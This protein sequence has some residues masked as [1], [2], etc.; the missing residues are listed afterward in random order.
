MLSAPVF[1][2]SL[3]VNIYGSRE[4]F[5]NEYRNLLAD[6]LLQSLNYDISREVCVA[7][8]API[9]SPYTATS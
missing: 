3:L 7:E 4:M 2:C 6:R 1:A 5:V 9:P 8:V